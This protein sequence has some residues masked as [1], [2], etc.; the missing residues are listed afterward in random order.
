[1]AISDLPLDELVR[2]WR[3]AKSFDSQPT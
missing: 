2:L 3:E 1:V